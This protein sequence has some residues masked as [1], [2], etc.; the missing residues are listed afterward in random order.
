MQRISIKFVKC[1][2]RINSA[3]SLRVKIVWSRASKRLVPRMDAYKMAATT[4]FVLMAD[5]GYLSVRV[6]QR[7]FSKNFHFCAC[8]GNTL[9]G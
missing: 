6:I 3:A 8:A 1:A 9:C 4:V 5:A 7:F 2:M